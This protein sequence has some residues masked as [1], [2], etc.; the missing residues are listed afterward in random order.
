M[1][2]FSFGYLRRNLLQRPAAVLFD[3]GVD[4]RHQP[5]GFGEGDV[6]GPSSAGRDFPSELEQRKEQQ[7]A[8]RVIQKSRIPDWRALKCP[9]GLVLICP[10]TPSAIGKHKSFLQMRL[11]Q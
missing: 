3:H 1:I 8:Q 9:H 7:R 2:P 4:L 5:D 6:R 10:V 11:L